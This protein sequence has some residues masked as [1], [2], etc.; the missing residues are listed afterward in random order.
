LTRQICKK[1][2]IDPSYQVSIKSAGSAISRNR[3]N[4][5]LFGGTTSL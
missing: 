3:P 1:L 2:F 4:Q 5:A